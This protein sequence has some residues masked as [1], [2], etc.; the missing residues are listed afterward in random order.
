MKNIQKYIDFVKSHE[1]QIVEFVDQQFDEDK[2]ELQE[3][4]LKI[5]AGYIIELPDHFEWSYEGCPYDFSGEINKD[6]KIS[7]DQT[8]SDISKNQRNR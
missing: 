3:K 7:L 8:I 2:E 5:I 1:E 4:I 6:G